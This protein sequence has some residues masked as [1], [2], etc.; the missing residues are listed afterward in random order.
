MKTQS[1]Q[2]NQVTDR[3]IINNLNNIINN[4][5][6]IYDLSSDEEQMSMGSLCSVVAPSSATQEKH[7]VKPGAQVGN[8]ASTLMT[9][10]DETIP[11]KWNYIKLD[12]F[13]NATDAELVRNK[14]RFK[15]AIAIKVDGKD[16]WV[17]YR[18]LL[19]SPFRNLKRGL[20]SDTY[21]NEHYTNVREAYAEIKQDFPDVRVSKTYAKGQF[22]KGQTTEEL[23]V[24]LVP[25]EQGY[26][27]N[28]HVKGMNWMWKL[29]SEITPKQRKNR[30]IGSLGIRRGNK[31]KNLNIGDIL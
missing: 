7:L 27:V 29:S 9:I 10:I 22:I 30:V 2:N 3:T 12:L 23:S 21:D 20:D 26:A 18:A 24:I 17:Y 1:P 13:N 5:N 4:N 16:E 15:L 8:P 11:A 31:I 25:L 6:N 14:N 28:L 19:N